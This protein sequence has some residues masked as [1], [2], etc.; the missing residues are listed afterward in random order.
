MDFVSGGILLGEFCPEIMSANY[1]VT[2]TALM[3]N[4]I[5]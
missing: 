5:T 3:N 4:V 2:K 1:V